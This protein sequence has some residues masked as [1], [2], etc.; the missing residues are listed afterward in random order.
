VPSGLLLRAWLG[1]R[2]MPTGLLQR[3]RL[4][5]VHVVCRRHVQRLGGCF[6]VR[7]MCCWLICAND[8][9]LVVC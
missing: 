8:G 9:P 7:G 1:Q 3:H 4:L 6:S 5:D 2:P